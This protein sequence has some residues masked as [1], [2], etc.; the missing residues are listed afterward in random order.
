[1]NALTWAAEQIGKPWAPDGEGPA[2][3]S[4][5]GL[6]RAAFRELHDIDMPHVAVAT[7]D[8]SQVRAIKNAA[9]VSR[10]RP[11]TG[12]RADGDIVLM[13]SRAKIH[14]GLVVSANGYLGV[15][16]SSHTCGVVYEKWRDA[17][18]GMTAELWRRDA[19]A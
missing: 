10:W 2:A 15:L 13:R 4:C 16:H 5:W 14:C 7:P 3:F 11:V 6:V 12:P 17:I 19:S 18:D 9:R 1:M 8:E